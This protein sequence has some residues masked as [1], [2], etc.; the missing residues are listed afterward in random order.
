MDAA[1]DFD[2]IPSSNLGYD[3]GDSVLQPKFDP[4]P[5]K[6]SLW[7]GF[8]IVLDYGATSDT[9]ST[10]AVLYLTDDFDSEYTLP[11]QEIKNLGKVKVKIT[12]VS[13]LS[14]PTI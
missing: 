5:S 2:H 6:V 11:L 13:R 3:F 10:G 9:S 12:S 1:I 7:E 8:G 14:P 4:N